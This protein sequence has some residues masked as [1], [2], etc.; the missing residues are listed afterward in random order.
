MKTKPQLKDH[1]RGSEPVQWAILFPVVLLI[2]FGSVQTAL[3]FDAKNTAHAA[4]SAAYFQARN[5]NSQGTDGIS[6]GQNLI[7]NTKSG[8]SDVN[9]SVDRTP[10]TVTATVTGQ[11]SKLLSFLPMPPIRETVTGPVDRFTN[12]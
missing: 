7:A 2:V 6:A 10:V 12:P 9:V 5:N 4:A 3:W 8:L 11:S 1:E